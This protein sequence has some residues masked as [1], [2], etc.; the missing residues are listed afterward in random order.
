M[1][2]NRVHSKI[3]GAVDR[4]EGERRGNLGN[5]RRKGG[6]RERKVSERRKLMW[7]A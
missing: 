6:F 4:T 3:V 2:E 5:L 7:N 1:G